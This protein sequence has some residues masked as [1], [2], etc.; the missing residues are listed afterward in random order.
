LD[1][2]GS[3]SIETAVE[4]HLGQVGRN[5]IIIFVSLQDDDASG[6][7]V[8][9]CSEEVVSQEVHSADIRSVRDQYP[10]GGRKPVS[11]GAGHVRGD[12]DV[13]LRT[14]EERGIGQTIVMKVLDAVQHA[15]CGWG[16]H[17]V[18]STAVTFSGNF[19]DEIAE[20]VAGCLLAD[21]EAQEAFS[22]CPF[23]PKSRLRGGDQERT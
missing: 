18:P 5:L 23:D 2:L 16:I 19:G 8:Y 21:S 11:G 13:E 17:V 7:V 10:P 20:Q 4:S 14:I 9:D 22:E 6:G 3:L 12:A 1:H 15:V